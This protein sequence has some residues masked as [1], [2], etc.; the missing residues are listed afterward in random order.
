MS[1]GEVPKQA[2]LPPHLKVTP[3]NGRLAAQKQAANRR[4]PFFELARLNA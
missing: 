3:I 4:F 1:S 2:Q